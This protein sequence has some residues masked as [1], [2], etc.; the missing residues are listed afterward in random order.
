MWPQGS[1]E[2]ALSI[3]ERRE[4]LEHVSCL[5]GVTGGHPEPWTGIKALPLGTS[6][7]TIY[8]RES[9]SGLRLRVAGQMEQFTAHGESSVQGA[10]RIGTVWAPN[11]NHD[12]SH[13]SITDCGP[14]AS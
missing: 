6:A 5:P 14:G 3:S 2:V 13:L 10:V 1:A 11:G 9:E 4:G 7:A 12:N 8:G